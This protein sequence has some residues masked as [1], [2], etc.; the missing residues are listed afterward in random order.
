MDQQS[1]RSHHRFLLLGRLFLEADK[2][3]VSVVD[4]NG[5]SDTYETIATGKYAEIP[6]VS[7]R[8][9]EKGP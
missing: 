4:R 2:T 1:T 9:I 7:A 6:L 5:I 3:I 8:R